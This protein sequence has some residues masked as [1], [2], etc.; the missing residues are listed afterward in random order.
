MI[1]SKAKEFPVGK[2]VAGSFG[3]RNYT[4]AT[5][6]EGDYLGFPPPRIVPDLKDLPLSL[7]LGVLGM[8]GYVFLL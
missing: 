6:K 4:I 5:N 1:E 8:P 3:W 2:Y 7:H